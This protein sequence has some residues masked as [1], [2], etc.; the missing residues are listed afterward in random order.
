VFSLRAGKAGFK[1]VVDTDI[2][3]GH[4]KLYEFT[5]DDFWAH[6][7]FDEIAPRCYAVIPVK[8]G[9]EM[10]EHLVRQLR[11]QPGCDGILI[12]DNGSNHKTRRRLAQLD[13]EIVP[14]V[15]MGI[16]E[17]WNL[18]AE[19][20]LRRWPKVD[21]AFLNND[22]DIGPDFLASLSADLRDETAP[23]R[24]AISPNYDGRELDAPEPQNQICANRYDGT[25]GAPGFAF[26]VKGEWFQLGYR[27]PEDAKW[28]FGDN[29]L[30]LAIRAAGGEWAITPNATVTHIGGGGQTGDWDAYQKSPQYDIDRKAFLARWAS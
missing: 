2:V 15:D 23:T 13:V 26:M 17:M 28:W 24:A 9:Y 29:D 27:F 19:I 21:L 1:V 6:V 4:R 8:D 10:T 20:A 14:A 30:L 18:G 5:P 16:H 11:S 22:L 7:P 25:G 12:L 3:C